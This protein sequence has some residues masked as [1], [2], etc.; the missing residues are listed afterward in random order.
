MDYL[1]LVNLLDMDLNILNKYPLNSPKYKCLLW[2]HNT[3]Y[4]TLHKILIG[5]FRRHFRCCD[6][7]GKIIGKG[8]QFRYGIDSQYGDVI[9]IMRPGDW[10]KSM[11]GVKLLPNSKPVKTQSPVIGHIFRDFQEYNKHKIQIDLELFNQAKKYN[12]RPKNIRGDGTECISDKNKKKT[13]LTWCYD[14]MHI[15]QNI[16]L[17]LVLKILVPRWILNNI[18]S[19]PDGKLLYDMITNNMP[20]FPDGSVNKLNGKIILY[21]PDN[22]KEHYTYITNNNPILTSKYYSLLNINNYQ[23]SSS[24]RRNLKPLGNSSQVAISP[25]AFFSAENIYMKLLKQHNCSF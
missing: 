24:T 6:E 21:G 1:E 5:E 23:K 8:A 4:E 20:M 2:T 17:G 14:Q 15:G 16:S 11:R 13:K 10:W 12:Y 3:P 25:K 22:I 18:E 7:K 19:I 9:F